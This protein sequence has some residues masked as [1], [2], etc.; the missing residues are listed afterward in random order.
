MDLAYRERLKKMR[1]TKT[2]TKFAEEL[3]MTKSNYS[4]IELGKVNA[5]ITALQR[6]AKITNSTL[7]VDLIP[8]EPTE[9]ESESEQITLELE[10]EEDKQ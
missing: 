3:G 2:V 4:K 6:I 5:S 8:N 10:I 7:V 1:G 9:L